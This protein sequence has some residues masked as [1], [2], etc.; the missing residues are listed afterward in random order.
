MAA[1]PGDRVVPAILISLLAVLLFDL[2]GLV[3]KHLSTSYGAAELSAWRNLFGLIPGLIALY[4]T[5]SWHDAGRPWRMRQWHIPVI[6]GIAVTFAQFC[7]YL[8][9]GRLAFATAAT[10]SYSNALFI[11]AL[12]VPILGERVGVFRWSAALIG[13]AG[14]VL[15]MGPGRDG[16]SLDAI[17]P[18][19]AAILYAVAG[20]T[21]RLLD[22]DVP[23]ALVNLHSSSIAAIG[24]LGL[25]LA[26]GGFTPVA[27]WADMGWIVA[28]GAFG[29]TAVLCIVV[30]Y[31]MTEPSNL[32]PFSY[33]G[34]PTALLLGWVFFGEAPIGDLFP[35]ALLIVLGGLM[36]VWRER[37]LARSL[38]KAD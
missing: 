28:M 12:S 8:A 22:D 24:A 33:F 5:R 34:I 18:L 7:F 32:A 17:L 29:G 30:A 9:L 23:S 25:A 2:M 31:R 11:V 4:S 16:F 14:V 3:I 13:F 1:R 38:A 15:V 35:G 37:R 21:S 10:I 36:I 6:R 20:V 26:T 19:A 27:S